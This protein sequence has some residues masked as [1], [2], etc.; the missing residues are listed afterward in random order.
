MMMHSAGIASVWPN[1]EGQEPADRPPGVVRARAHRDGPGRPVHAA[2]GGEGVDDR[3]GVPQ[4][5]ERADPPGV[6]ADEEEIAIVYDDD[7]VLRFERGG[8][9]GAGE[10]ETSST[11]GT[12]CGGRRSR[13]TTT[14]PTKGVPW[15]AMDAADPAAGR[16]QHDPV[17]HL[18]AMQF[19]AF[20]QRIVTGFDP[21]RRTRTGTS[22]TRRTQTASP[23]VDAQGQR[24][25]GAEHPGRAGVDRMLAFPGGDTK[26]FDLPESNL[27]TTS[28][29]ERVPGAVLLDRADPAAVPA[30]ADGEPLRRRARRRGVDPA[31]LVREL[32]LAAAEGNETLSE[33]AWY[34]MGKTKEFSPDVETQWADAEARSFAQIVDAIVKL[35]SRASRSGRRSG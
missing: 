19:S 20:R 8:L 16:D 21:R 10:W 2:V 34:A 5:G 28:R 25:P 29:S 7:S 30:R 27:G 14:R 6:D 33:L 17:Q 24:D 35:I 26:V 32:Q 11:A 23:K 18:L 4:R 22:S 31:S 1:K 13:S 3:G 15:S 9:A 12:R